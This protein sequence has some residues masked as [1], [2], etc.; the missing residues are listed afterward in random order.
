MDI[1]QRRQRGMR[2]LEEMLGPGQAE[3]ARRVWH[4]LSPD[5]EGYILE[6]VSGE[7]WN[8]PG[9]DRRTRSLTT[10]AALTALGR[11]QALDLNIRLALNNGATRQEV[12]ETLLHLAV[13]A[14][15]PACWEG[16]TIADKV[17]RELDC[18]PGGGR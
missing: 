9:L 16:L 6:F 15:F 7:M 18:Q 17:F 10:I 13:Y 3:L 4:D 12:L 1:E 2:V 14:G 8:R 11:P 5:F